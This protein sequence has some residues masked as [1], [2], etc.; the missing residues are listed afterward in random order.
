MC[1]KD[2]GRVQLNL[3]PLP[4]QFPGQGGLTLFFDVEMFLKMHPANSYQWIIVKIKRYWVWNDKVYK[5]L[6]LLI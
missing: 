4:P 6:Q 2:K 1:P 3:Y 5:G